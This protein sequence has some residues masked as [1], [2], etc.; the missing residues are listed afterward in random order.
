MI[1]SRERK[2]YNDNELYGEIRRERERE[3]EI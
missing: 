3:R 1:K 2:T